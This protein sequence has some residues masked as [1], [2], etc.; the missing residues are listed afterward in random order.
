MSNGLP[1]FCRCSAHALRTQR[2]C[3]GGSTVSPNSSELTP[4]GGLSLVS[5][6]SLVPHALLDLTRFRGHVRAGQL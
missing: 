1:F 3:V 5:R 4:R 6:V 2:D